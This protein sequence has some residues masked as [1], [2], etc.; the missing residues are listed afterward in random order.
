[1]FVQKLSVTSPTPQDTD[2]HWRWMGF[3]FIGGR[4]MAQVDD[5]I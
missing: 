4:Q 5:P 3:F 2:A 1:M